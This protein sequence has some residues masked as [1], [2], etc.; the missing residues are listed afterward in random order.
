MP[1]A[2]TGSKA[3]TLTI[4]VVQAA[5]VQV[6]N[7]NNYQITFQ[8]DGLGVNTAKIEG[9]GPAGEYVQIVA[10]AADH[11]IQ[12]VGLASDPYYTAY[13]FTASAGTLTVFWAAVE[14]VSNLR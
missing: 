2:I 13:R 5:D 10:A 7:L 12:M 9:M 8:V 3:S 14:K 11:A 4:A 6:S 1:D